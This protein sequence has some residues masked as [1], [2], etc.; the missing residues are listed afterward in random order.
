MLHVTISVFGFV[1]SSEV[2]KL[3]FAVGDIL[4][5]IFVCIVGADTPDFPL[6]N[7]VTFWA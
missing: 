6:Q 2:P 3:K 4:L 5:S 1:V 7:E